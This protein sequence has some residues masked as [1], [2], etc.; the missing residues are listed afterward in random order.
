MRGLFAEL[1]RRNVLRAG[2]LYVGAV[3]AL[4]Q[5]IAQLGPSLGAPDA[6]TRW[7][8]VASAVGFPFWIALAWF[9]E[10]TP[11]GLRREKA[12]DPAETRVRPYGRRLD[13][14]II[15]V[16]TLA[17]VLLVTERLVLRPDPDAEVV[18]SDTSIAVLPFLNLSPDRDQ[19]YFADG[20]SEEL[21]N[22][23][24]KVPDLTVVARTSSF[25]FKGAKTGIPEIA[26]RL[27]VAYVLE[28]SVRKADHRVR[29]TAKLVRA[30]D[31]VHLWS[32][33][34][35]RE[36]DDIFAI[37]DEIAAEVAK[38]LS[39]RLLGNAP[40]TRTTDPEAFTLYLRALQ[41]GRQFTAEAFA[42]SDALYRDVLAIDPSYAPAWTGLSTNAVNEMSLGLLS[43]EQGAVRARES[44]ARAFEIDPESAR[45]YA[46]VGWLAMVE[47][48][49]AD[50]SRHF[51]RAL[52]LDPS[53][54]NVLG[55]A[56]SLLQSLGRPGEALA[57]LEAIV[58]RDPL[59]VSAIYNLAVAQR[60]AG[61]PEQAIASYYTVLSLSPGRG[62]AH[63]GLGMALL[64][65]GDAS[66]AL[67]EI[68]RETSE[69]WRMIAL[70][71]AYHALGRHADSDAALTALIESYESDASYNIASIYAYRGEADLAFEWLDKAI[72][73]EDPGL[74][75]IVIDDLFVPVR[76]DPRWLPLLRRLGKAPEQL[77]KI[78]FDV[79]LP[80]AND[81]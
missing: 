77:E 61:Q 72:Q 31:S 70:P 42:K 46:S 16:L 35:D 13:F 40:R 51:E 43:T 2:V 81:P 8:L 44:A 62:G 17:V 7:F 3:W 57:L 41:L 58:R 66:G 36:L 10:L 71:E 6:M 30:A 26:Q 53:D 67:A 56:A 38:G 33:S 49:L 20:I 24:A 79:V 25:A 64:L 54:L 15:A 69:F 19:E 14:A 47:N 78:D 18:V 65:Q 68:E 11:T 1:I 9:F 75:E 29:V 27:R 74:S 28:G 80:A 21:L 22:L 39:V 60:W 12:F 37:Q 50:A 48:N 32:N 52:A 63:S 55:N 76:S 4:A 5:G 34:W 73:Y 45:A 59:N 23:L